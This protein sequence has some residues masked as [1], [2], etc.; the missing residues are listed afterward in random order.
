MKL[1]YKH[2][3][4]IIHDYLKQQLFY[5]YDENTQNILKFML[6][7][8]KYTYLNLIVHNLNINKV[9]KALEDF[10]KTII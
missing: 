4:G 6:Q 3:T 5:E 10:E 9:T 7:Y 1:I 8:N 2:S